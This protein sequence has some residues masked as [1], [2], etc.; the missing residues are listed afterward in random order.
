MSG[1]RHVPVPRSEPARPHSFPDAQLPRVA[2]KLRNAAEHSV[3]IRQRLAD[4]DAAGVDAHLAHRDFVG[5]AAL[6]HNRD[7]ATYL[8]ECLE[9]ANEQDGIREVTH[10]NGRRYL[11]PDE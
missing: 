6:L 5:A 3:K 2:R 4:G 7:R 11:L 10:V 8:T 1:D 9:V